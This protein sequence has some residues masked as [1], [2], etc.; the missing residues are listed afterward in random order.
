VCVKSTY[1]IK[2]AKKNISKFHVGVISDLHNFG[3]Q[4]DGIPFIGEVFFVLVESKDGDRYVHGKRFLGVKVKCDKYGFNCFIDAREQAQKH[5]E[6]LADA[7][8]SCGKIDLL[9]WNS[10]RPAYGSNAYIDYGQYDDIMS[11]KAEG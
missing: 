6:R 9:Y 1:T 10:V 5:A 8:K 3:I 7:V 2:D 4:E 11:E